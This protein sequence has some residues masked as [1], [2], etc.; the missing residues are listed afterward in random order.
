MIIQDDEP[1]TI[2]MMA[3]HLSIDGMTRGATLFRPDAFPRL[4]KG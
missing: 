2:V 1:L 4:P 3:G